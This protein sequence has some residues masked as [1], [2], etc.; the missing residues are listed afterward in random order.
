MKYRK[1]YEGDNGWTKWIR[2]LAGYRVACCSCGV[3]HDLE[4]RL[5]ENNSFNFRAR[6]NPR[7]TAQ[8]QRHMKETGQ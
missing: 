5:D 2:P 1:E 7:A 6:Q 4:F 8:K 3:V